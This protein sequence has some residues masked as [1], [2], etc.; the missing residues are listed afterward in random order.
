M[1]IHSKPK[2]MKSSIY[3]R[4]ITLISV[5]LF[6]IVTCHAQNDAAKELVG[7]WTK[8]IN[9]RTIT[10]VMTSD[11]KYEVEFAGDEEID[12]LGSYVIEKNQITFTDEGGEY[13]SDTSG[14]YEFKVSESSVIFTA[15][16]DPANGRR[17]LVA[18]E[19]TKAP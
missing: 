2:L 12:V 11:L 5:L 1:N 19:W 16:D 9:S 3:T 7:T 14:V 8:T 6:S 13:G 10:F 4:A 18:G 17:M 15:V